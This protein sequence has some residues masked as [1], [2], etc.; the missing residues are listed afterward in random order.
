MKKYKGLVIA[1]VTIVSIIYVSFAF[2]IN[3]FNTSNWT[4][5]ERCAMILIELG[6]LIT[7]IPYLI[8][9]DIIDP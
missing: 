7:V 4:Y 6:S 1:I 8:K 9:I 3:D 2:A 5:G